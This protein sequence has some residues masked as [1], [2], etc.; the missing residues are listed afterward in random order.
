[1]TGAD[2][3]CTSTITKPSSESAM[4]ATVLDTATSLTDPDVST[5]LSKPWYGI[6]SHLAQV[7]ASPSAIVAAPTKLLTRIELTTIPLC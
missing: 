4:Y 7:T 3:I 6:G 5:W 1:M 2:G